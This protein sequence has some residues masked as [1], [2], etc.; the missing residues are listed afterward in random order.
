MVSAFPPVSHSH[1][2]EGVEVLGE[3]VLRPLVV[4]YVL[5]DFCGAFLVLGG[6]AALHF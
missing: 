5:D 3:G 4:D 1:H 2:V 6:L